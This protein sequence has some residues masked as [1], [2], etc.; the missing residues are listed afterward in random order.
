MQQLQHRHTMWMHFVDASYDEL[1]SYMY[2]YV[3][4]CVFYCAYFTVCIVLL[5]RRNKQ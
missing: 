1:W 3:I 4:L 5:L 2:F